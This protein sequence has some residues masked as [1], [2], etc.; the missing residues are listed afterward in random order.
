MSDTAFILQNCTKAIGG[1]DSAIH[2]IEQ[3][4]RLEQAVS[5]NDPALTLD[6]AKSLLE[7]IFKTIL[8]DRQ[9]EPNFSGTF[10]ALYSEVRKEIILNNE[11][12]ANEILKRLT[13]SIVHNVGELRNAY[14]AASHG[15]DGYYENPIQ[16]PEAEMIAHIVDGM[17]GFLFRKHKNLSDPEQAQRIF[18]SDYAV[19]NDWLDSQND[20]IEI[21]VNQAEDIPFSVFLFTY[22]V[23]T[24]RAMLLQYVQT[25]EEDAGVE[26]P[27]VTL[28]A[29][30]ETTEAEL[31]LEKLTAE[32]DVDPV[33]EI[34][35][36]L[37]INEEVGNAISDDDRVEI[38][39]FAQDYALNRAGLDWQSRDSLIAKF[40]I[41]IKR[42]LIKKA[43]TEHCIDEAIE[44]V[45][46]KA[47]KYFPSEV[48]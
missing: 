18:Y 36:A 5:S 12:A 13:S 43:F 42:T 17:G 11:S 46:E 6:T 39:E 27:E 15:D 8:T 2:L 4:S 20:P 1:A 19:F 14:G 48:A 3:K 45:I 10:S 35:A 41:Q 25:E 32:P 23:D 7:S 47:M 24:Y 38:A 9:A 31:P 22:D 26:V 34:A 44:V 40:R 28:V 33:S 30:P 21:P 16:M 37:V 29:E